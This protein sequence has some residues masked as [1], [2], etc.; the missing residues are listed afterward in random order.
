VCI[1]YALISSFS[2]HILLGERFSHILTHIDERKQ[3]DDQVKENY[4][5]YPIDPTNDYC[6]LDNAILCDED[7]FGKCKRIGV[8]YTETKQG[9]IAPREQLILGGMQEY[10]NGAT[11]LW[12]T[13]MSDS[14]NHLFPEG[15]RHVRAHSHMFAATLAPTG[16]DSF[17][18]EYLLQMDVGGGLPYFMIT[19]A[20]IS[21]VKNLFKYA[22]DYY[23]GGEGSELELYLKQKYLHEKDDEYDKME[24]LLK[25]GD[26]VIDHSHPVLIDNE[27][28]LFTP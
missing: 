4:E 27:S 15:K 3:W 2:I 12:G 14:Q 6:R 16:Q 24:S 25:E 21:T 23:A 11:I 20:I 19:P 17:D 28:I 8:G 18:V 13:E 26:M 7:R 5:I 10:E 9:I 22:E 1:S